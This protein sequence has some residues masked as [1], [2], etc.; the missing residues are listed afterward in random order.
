MNPKILAISTYP[1]LTQMLKEISKE[2]GV[3]ISI[4][5]GGIMRDGHLYAKKMENKF[6]IIISQGGTL[7]AIKEIVTIPVVSIEISTADILRALLEA[8]EKFKKK[9]VLFCYRSEKLSKLQNL[10]DILNVDFEV[11]NYGNKKEFEEKVD[12]I[13]NKSEFTLVGM[14]SCMLETSK[15]RDVD[16]VIIKSNR[17]SVRQAII[18]A[19]NI[20]DLSKREKEKSERLKIIIDYSSEGIIAVDK[21]GFITTFNPVAE[22]IFDLESDIVLGRNISDLK[23]YYYL[24]MVYGDEGYK[25][26][27]IIKINNIQLIIN[28]IPIIVEDEKSGL[29][30]TLQ[31]ISKLQKLEQNVRNKLYNK[32]LIAKHRFGEILGSSKAIKEA[33]DNGIRFGKTSTTILI[34]GETGSGK[35]LFAQSIHNIS[36]RKDKPFVAV[37]CAAL[38][39]NLLESELFGY[40]EGAFTGAK[41]GGKLGLFEMAHGGTIFLDEIGEIPLSLQSRLLR[42]LQEKE[43]L[44]IGGDYIVKVDVR[45]I[46][47]TN[48]DLYKMVKEHKFR[49]DLYFRLNILNLKIPPIRDRKEDIPILV[50]EFIGRMNREH[51]KKIEGLTENA[52]KLLMAYSW[53]G[54][55]REIQ[56]FVERMVI[57]SDYPTIE[58]KFIRNLFIQSFGRENEIEKL[59][60]DKN[61]IKVKVGTLK[62]MELQLIEE[63]NNIFDSNK[64]LLA[65]K[66]GISRTTLWKKM[67]EMEEY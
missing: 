66:L 36:D 47:A 25:L 10:K 11:V 46:S 14:G 13:F 28:R 34:Q 43:V 40:E 57:L 33:I 60:E 49:E 17:N 56:N 44:R 61:T 15:G 55:V 29:I 63:L 62:D 21:Q 3:A 51:N 53:P 19:K 24:N 12:K 52:M 18:D 32:G 42:V 48:I 26:D 4:Y 7:E 67:K 2:L 65:E 20:C 64:I 39:E 22:K 45:I 59:E 23:D 8:K 50:N 16:A 41:K 30:I 37:N 6:D 35:E 38:P 54:N 27:E 5:E 1:E 31:E 9:I 58:E